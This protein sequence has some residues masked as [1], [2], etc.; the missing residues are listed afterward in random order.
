MS[1][2]DFAGR[3]AVVLGVAD[4]LAFFTWLGCVI[5]N[6][7]KPVVASAFVWGAWWTVCGLSIAVA[8]ISTGVID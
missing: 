4:A 7:D 5:A 6:S 3:F 2:R 8:S 1:I